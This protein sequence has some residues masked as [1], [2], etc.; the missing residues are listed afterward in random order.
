MKKIMLMLLAIVAFSA[1]Q[2]QTP[3]E[4]AKSMAE[5]IIKKHIEVPE[6]YDLLKFSVDTAYAPIETPEVLAKLKQIVDLNDEVT[7][8]NEEMQKKYEA[9]QLANSLSSRSSFGSF[10][11]N[12][13]TQEYKE[14]LA[15][16]EQLAEKL[17]AS[18]DEIQA[19]QEQPQEPIGLKIRVSYGSTLMD[20]TPKLHSCYILT[21]YNISKALAT[22]HDA[23]TRR[24]SDF[25]N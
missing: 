22:Y 20:G 12:K 3:E 17:Q 25:L 4:K 21:N 11:N 7:A 15:K 24:M 5:D 1:C 16:Y 18:R 19:L 14:A 2:Q 6:S 10:Q 9:Y 8:A 13:H 23:D